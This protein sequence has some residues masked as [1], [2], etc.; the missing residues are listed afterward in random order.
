MNSYICDADLSIDHACVTKLKKL[1]QRCVEHR[2]NL[3]GSGPVKVN[4]E[5]QAKGLHGKKYQGSYMPRY[6]KK[7]AR[8]LCNGKKCSQSYDPINWFVDYKSGF[9]FNPEKY[10][11]TEKCLAVMGTAPG[12]DIKCPWE[13]GRLY[14]LPQLAVLAIVD[15]TMRE[16]IM[17]EFRDEVTD[18]MQM[19]PIGKTVQWAAPM[20]ISIRMVNMLVS[21][22][23]LSQLDTYGYFGKEFQQYF[24]EH[25]RKSLI[26]VMENLEYSGRISANHYLAN[27]SGII[28]AAAYL[29]K[30]SWVDS[31]LVFGVQELIEQVG[32]QFYVEGANIEG[33]TSYHRLCTE[34]VLYS[35]AL[36]YGVLKTEKRDAFLEYDCREIKRLKSFSQQRY[37]VLGAEFFPQEFLDRVCR[38]GIFTSIVLKNNHEIVQI[39]D[40]DSGRL[41]KLTPVINAE[42]ND[43]EENDL[44]HRTLL[45]AMSGIFN[46]DEFAES[47]ETFPLEASLIHS[48]SKKKQIDGKA[49]STCLEEYGSP[50]KTNQLYE[51]TKERVLFEDNNENL[52]DGVKIHYFEEF[53]VVVFRGSRLFLSMV[54][55][56][57]R[58][59]MYSGHTHNDKLSIEVMVNG[60]YITRDPGG[61]IYTAFQKGR[62]GFRS[63]KAHNTICVAG[64]EQNEFDGNWS[65]KKRV[66]AAL[67]YCTEN[68]LVARVTYGD[69]ACQRDIRIT[70]HK[71]I[72]KDSANKPFQ[73]RFKNKIYSEG[74]GRLKKVMV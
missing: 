4:Y 7:I 6:G 54:I 59:T 8:K 10:N 46:N 48:L 39:G 26:F 27:L 28:F 41:L 2:F 17:L 9:F 33:S 56:T 67:L 5:L 1:Y 43:M 24:E 57:A 22:D 49:Y 55:D 15:E 51:Y 40:N 34:L 53:G 50:E 19:N 38:A 60:T 25:I 42:A 52:L 71:I 62:D 70:D 44:D 31:C 35:V 23:I 16:R 21:Y 66:R 14:H 20:D 11:S 61:Y 64:Y 12:A 30:D 18:F 47:G 72:I 13:L 73:S 69:V 45:S 29:P 68:R 58:N 32:R 65:M 37:D 74:S 3:L 63:V 36:V